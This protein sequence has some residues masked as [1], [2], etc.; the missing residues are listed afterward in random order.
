MRLDIFA[1][2]PQQGIDQALSLGWMIVNDSA[3]RVACQRHN[4][5]RTE[6]GK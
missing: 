3:E 4:P 6:F 2:T 1:T 5:T